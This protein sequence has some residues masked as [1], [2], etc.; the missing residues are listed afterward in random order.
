LDLKGVK[1]DFC[2]L[3]ILEL[4]YFKIMDQFSLSFFE[5]R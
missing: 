1:Y 5:I 2:S 3:Q 4:V